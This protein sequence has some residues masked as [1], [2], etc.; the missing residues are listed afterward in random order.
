MRFLSEIR[1]YIGNYH[2]KSALY[3]Y[4]RNEF[5]AAVEFLEKALKDETSLPEGDRKTATT[6]LTLSL[7][8]L[9]EKQA[10]EGDLEAGIAT[11]SA[12][13]KVDPGFPDIH[14]CVATLHE[15]SGR[16]KDAIAAYRRA[17]AN[18]PGYLEAHVALGYCLL[19]SGKH[20]RAAEHFDRALELK[21]SVFRSE[22]DKGTQALRVPD[23]DAARQSFFQVFRASPELA[24]RHL[25]QALEWIRAEKFEPALDELEQ[26]LKFNP[27]YSDLHNFRGIAL[28][29]LEQYEEAFEAFRCSA[30]LSPDHVVP[31]LNLA[32]AFFRADRP[33]EGRIALS[34]VLGVNPDEPAAL[35]R[36]AELESAEERGASA[37]T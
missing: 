13:A 6:Y 28:T 23:D 30:T 9:G 37:R 34:E 20:D 12:A 1:N 14:F 15:K 32:F 35:A 19:A 16:R 26:A 29:E 3:H 18:H 31:R 10:A 11:L 24:Q 27:T 22:F 33:A 5:G 2:V 7:K 17:I 8:G 21:L 36:I 25:D 4:Y